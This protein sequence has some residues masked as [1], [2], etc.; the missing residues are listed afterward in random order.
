LEPYLYGRSVPTT[1]QLFVPHWLFNV[2]RP[3]QSET[4]I[5]NKTL[6]VTDLGS[7]LRIVIPS[8]VGDNKIKRID[9]VYRKSAAFIWD[10]REAALIN[11]SYLG[12]KRNT[13]MI[14]QFYDTRTETSWFGIV[15]NSITELV[16]TEYFSF[17]GY[18]K[19]AQLDTAELS[20]E[21]IS[22]DGN[23]WT[24]T[25]LKPS[26]YT[27]E[28][29][30][31]A[32]VAFTLVEHGEIINVG[33]KY[34]AWPNWRKLEKGE[35]DAAGDSLYW[36]ND[37]YKELY[38]ITSDTKW[39]NALNS[40]SYTIQQSHDID[41]ARQIFKLKPGT[42]SA[43]NQDG[44]F[45]RSERENF[46]HNSWYRDQ[47]GAVSAFLKP[48][49]DS[50][51]Q[52][53]RGVNDSWRS[54]TDTFLAR[55]E[56]YPF[57]QTL[58][59]DQNPPPV[60][61]GDTYKVTLDAYVFIDTSLVFSEQT[62]YYAKIDVT[63]IGVQDYVFNLADFVT[64]FDSLN[65]THQLTSGSPIKAAGISVFS[66]SVR[67]NID[68]F[69]LK[70]VTQDQYNAYTVGVS[71]M[72]FK[73]H[74]MRPIPEIILPYVPFAPMYTV[75]MLNNEL[76]DWRGVP[77]SGYT[78]PHVWQEIGITAGMTTQLSFLK[79]AQL[80]YKNYFSASQS[81]P[82]IPAF[83]WDREDARQYG[84]VNS[85]GWSWVDPNSQWGG[86][87]YRALQSVAKAAQA[88]GNADAITITTN[89]L[90]WLNSVWT[91]HTKFPPTDFPKLIKP[92]AA[93]TQF[94]A[95]F[96]NAVIDISRPTTANGFVYKPLNTGI[97]GTSQPAWPATLYST[98]V[99]GGITWECSGY[100][101]DNAYGNYNEPHM[102]SM[103]LRAAIFG[104]LAGISTAVTDPLITRCYNYLDVNFI[105]SGEFAGSW[106]AN[107]EWWMFWHAEII[108]TLAILLQNSSI[109]TALSLNS[110]T[111][112]NWLS[113]SNTFLNSKTRSA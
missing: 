52:I 44:T 83:Y 79:E 67:K 27:L 45:S 13:E 55:L 72:Y 2:K 15:S 49:Q 104:R 90:T 99:D 58:T 81:G 112:N 20:I 89:Y 50:E 70:Y 66:N 61:V 36:A 74:L 76:V 68:T 43:Y 109:I 96:Y 69:H 19:R 7:T 11:F 78:Y 75:N 98:V 39:L 25:V 46:G 24:I 40:N 92:W 26:D 14:Q 107:G 28:V 56:I 41:D 62:R 60:P 73:I 65:P 17:Q 42:T 103:I 53:G 97:S 82:F 38:A 54:P 105:S 111:I 5:L 29:D 110:T 32:I 108:G 34:E 71:D 47:I 91:T 102:T 6:N 18:S 63:A 87:Q 8:T 100:H 37:A 22:Y 16:K 33:D 9:R 94:N 113:M 85:W 93:S 35:I 57:D 95:G 80:Q 1:T 21:S 10:N 59:I 88:S 101:Y 106:S 30:D 3:F 48:A 12:I 23:D 51:I 84:P 77:G 86:Y 64:K 31:Q 4:S